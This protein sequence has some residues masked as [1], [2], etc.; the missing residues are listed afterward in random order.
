LEALGDYTS[1]EVQMRRFWTELAHP[2]DLLKRKD[3][4]LF[5]SYHIRRVWVGGISLS[6]NCGSIKVEGL[7]HKRL[8]ENVS[9]VEQVAVVAITWLEGPSSTS[10]VLFSRNE[11]KR[12]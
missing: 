3:L 7:W 1:L 10:T 12:K 6:Q 9:I 5:A 4:F 8:D 11:Q 2:W